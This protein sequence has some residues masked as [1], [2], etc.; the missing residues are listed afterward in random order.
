MSSL[1]DYDNTKNKLPKDLNEK[2]AESEITRLNNEINRHDKLYHGK[3]SPKISDA[4]YDKLR[5]RLLELEKKYP[6]L[7]EVANS[8]AKK[9][10]A[11]P[12]E[13]F[14][15]IKH[16]VPML[17]LANAFSK[18]D[19]DDFIARVSRFLA[20][21]AKEITFFAEPKIDGL[22]FSARFENGK[23]MQAS[24]RGDGE[25][26]E[27]ITE[28]IKTLQN[29]PLK[30]LGGNLPKII[31]IRG[32]VYMSHADFVH[33]NAEQE[34][35]GSKIFANPRNA[36]AGSLRQLDASITKSRSLRYFAYGIGEVDDNF[37]TS[38]QEM[39][40][41]FKDLGFCTNDLSGIL[42][43]SDEIMNYY[44]SLYNKRPDLAYD[45]DGIV[46]KINDKSYQAR[47]GNVAR[48][49]RWAIAHKFPA[50]QAIT[51]LE[52]IDIQVGRTGAL[53]PVA[54]LKPVNVGGVIV[55]RA[56]LHNEDEIARKDIRQGDYVVI[57]R[58]GDVIPQVVKSDPSKRTTDSKSYAF[59]L[60]CPVCK[61]ETIR[62]EGEVIRRCS[63]GL[64]CR[65]QAV[66][67]LKHFVSRNAFDIE[68]L[69]EKQIDSFWQ[70]KILNKPIDIFY[71][72]E[73]DKSS[74][75]SIANREGWGKKSAEKLFAA[76]NQRK[77]ISLDR[78]IF[79]LGVRYIG[80]TT[81][82]LLAVNY[83]NFDNWQ[84]SMRAAVDKNSDAYEFLLSIDGVGEKVAESLTEFFH[85]EH[86]ANGLLELAR[87][88]SIS[89]VEAAQSDSVISGKII[90]FTGSLQKTTR[91]EAK[92]KAENLGAK[93]SGSV[94]AK[95]D[96][97]VAG[98][99]AGSKLKK[100]ESLGVKVLTED[101][102]I[103]MAEIS[104][105]K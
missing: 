5:K 40:Q 44:E 49:P 15:K 23:F 6:D 43:N 22:S 91:A 67:Q 13:G 68:G 76:I 101:E 58:A 98:E 100:A 27:D 32:E 102:W 80:A 37:A 20:V 1:F 24:T 75:T 77:N 86:N 3:D 61:S 94:S 30:L 103:A 19:I 36:A 83:N 93:V 38:Q 47:L 74:L 45:I 2:Q 29:F 71:L 87:V 56:T 4:E 7:T 70:A 63:G 84:S 8:V 66:E 41:K 26:G 60:E 105:N 82:K 78:F 53:T 39:I 54:H 16:I 89:D 96:Y 69:G 73:R 18:E 64:V 97:V 104:D 95:T 11:A 92:A 31:E 81:A 28:N 88:L 50:E 51:I 17:S 48:S 79:A 72:E 99:A 9:V 34:K 25:T 42:R 85:E 52:K 12:S 90:V 59:P 65:A 10:G 57:Q 21:D 55:S 14:G 46:Y 62:P 35:S 33:L